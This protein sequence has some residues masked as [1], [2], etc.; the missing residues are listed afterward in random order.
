MG[1]SWRAGQT[2]SGEFW[3]VETDSFQFKSG[4]TSWRK[5][6]GAGPGGLGMVWTYRRS[7][8]R[9]CYV[10]KYRQQQGVPETELRMP[11]GTQRTN[12]RG[13]LRAG[14]HLAGQAESPGG[15]SGSLKEPS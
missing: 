10:C 6:T 5:G 13:V 11:G 8:G 9:S 3:E 12:A 4:K 14:S 7:G 15:F 1:G 2:K